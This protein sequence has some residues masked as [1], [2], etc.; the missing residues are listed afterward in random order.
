MRGIKA[1]D[2]ADD[3]FGTLLA[4]GIVAMIT[5]QVFMNIGMT[6]GLMPITGVPLPLMSYGGSS[7]F[8]TYA[9]IGLLLNVRLKRQ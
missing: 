5:T 4:I 8:A 9:S 7:L 3:P 6:L 1:A 2:K